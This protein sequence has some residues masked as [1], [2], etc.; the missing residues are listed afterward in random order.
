MLQAC[1]QLDSKTSPGNVWGTGHSA[2]ALRKTLHEYTFLPTA[3]SFL[4]IGTT[5]PI[6]ADDSYKGVCLLPLA[7]LKAHAPGRDLELPA[8]LPKV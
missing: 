8:R 7:A 3:L 1:A 2:R 5:L 4:P 6:R